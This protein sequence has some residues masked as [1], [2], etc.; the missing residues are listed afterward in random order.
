MWAERWVRGYGMNRELRKKQRGDVGVRDRLR[1][2]AK[3]GRRDRL[4]DRLV[5]LSCS[6][7]PEQCR[8][9][10]RRPESWRRPFPFITPC[11]ASIYL[12]KASP[13]LCH[14]GW[15]HTSPLVPCSY[16][17]SPRPPLGLAP[18]GVPIWEVPG[19][20][21]VCGYRPWRRAPAAP[22]VT[23]AARPNPTVII[24]YCTR[25]DIVSC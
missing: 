15:G 24:F 3:W 5:T 9:W 1:R 7:H 6:W 20:G 11:S 16:S 8:G 2:S 4:C 13:D 19:L 22:C 18:G 14:T 17:F 12:T 25:L 10:G 21:G 23:T